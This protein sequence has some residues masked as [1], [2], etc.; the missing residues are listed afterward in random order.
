MSSSN[1]AQA[2]K[3]VTT[4]AIAQFDNAPAKQNAIE[5]TPSVTPI[6]SPNNLPA[7]ANNPTVAVI[8]AFAVLVRAILGSSSSKR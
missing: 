2:Q 8:L 1:Q 6:D 4:Q 5:S 3:Q 7:I